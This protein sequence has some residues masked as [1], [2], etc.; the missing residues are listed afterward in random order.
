MGEEARTA[1]TRGTQKGQVRLGSTVGRN[2]EDCAAQA[3]H[4]LEK[5]GLGLANR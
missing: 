5:G 1:R 2:E 4:L 3:S